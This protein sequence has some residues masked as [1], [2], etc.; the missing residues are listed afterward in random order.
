MHLAKYKGLAILWDHSFYGASLPLPV[1]VILSYVYLCYCSI[2]KMPQQISGSS[3]APKKALEDVVLFA[4]LFA[5]PDLAH[6][7]TI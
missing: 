3:S 2:R 6:P 5:H 7:C 4:N 1:N